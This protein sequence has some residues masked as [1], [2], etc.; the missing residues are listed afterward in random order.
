MRVSSR[1]SGARET[2]SSRDDDRVQRVPV[3][4]VFERSAPVPKPLK[5]SRR[6]G[7]SVVRGKTRP[8]SLSAFRAAVIAAHGTGE[9]A[10]MSSSQRAIFA[11]PFVLTTWGGRRNA[12]FPDLVT[13]NFISRCVFNMAP[14]MIG[15]ETP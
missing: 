13:A 9:L 11:A 2:P 7:S 3:V 8:V 14:E 6:G 12:G 15:P 10:R 5:A 1:T 4:D